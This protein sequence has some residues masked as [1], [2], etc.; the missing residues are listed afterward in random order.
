M[1]G[2]RTVRTEYPCCKGPAIIIALVDVPRER[3]QRKCSSCLRIWDVRRTVLSST[4][5][6]IVERFEWETTRPIPVEA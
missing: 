3:Y 2:R 4:P 5:D 6:I 1:L